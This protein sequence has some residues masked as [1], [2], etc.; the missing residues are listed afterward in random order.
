MSQFWADHQIHLLYFLGVLL[1]IALSN[2]RA[3]R[4]LGAYRGIA[5]AGAHPARRVSVLVPLRH[6]LA[7]AEPCLR[8]LLAQDYPHYELLALDDESNDGTLELLQDLA[9]S[10]SRLRVLRGLPLPPGWLGKNWAC[11]QLAEAATGELLFF[12][13]ADTRHAPEALRLAVAALESEAVDLVSVFPRQQV[14][15]WAERLVVPIMQWSISSFFPLALSYRVRRPHL[16]VA[17]GQ[18]MLFRREA[19]RQVGGHAA[20]R[21]SPIEDVALTRAL[22]NS[23]KR[24]RLLDGERLVHCRM[25]HHCREVADGYGKNLFPLFGYNAPGFLF[26]WLYLLSAF[27]EPVLVLVLS[28]FGPVHP[29]RVAPA[30]AAVILSLLLWGFTNWR[31]GFPLYLTLLYPLTVLCSVAVAL[32]SMAL[33]LLGRTSWKGRPL[34]RS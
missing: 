30:A 32:R 18:C 29:F 7:N 21:D 1:V 4:R 34:A 10:D 12:C 19:Y 5:T 2:L 20:V 9:R 8:S 15:S 28:R 31:F 33:T 14:G 3:W 23:G 25:Y 16:S 24:W 22:T 27:W 13:D 11:H 26:I 6:E 17:S